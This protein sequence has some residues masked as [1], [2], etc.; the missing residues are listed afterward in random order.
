MAR[1]SRGQ[2]ALSTTLSMPKAIAAPANRTERNSSAL[3]CEAAIAGAIQPDDHKSTNR[4]GAMRS[5][6]NE[7]SGGQATQSRKQDA[8][9]LTQSPGKVKAHSR[10]I[11]R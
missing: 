5:R 2:R 4:T 3:E 11:H 10:H 6:D 7:S 1:G 9:E 8:P